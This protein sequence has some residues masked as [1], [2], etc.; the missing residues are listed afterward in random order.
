MQFLICFWGWDILQ[1]PGISDDVTT[2]FKF[3]NLLGCYDAQNVKVVCK[4]DHGGEGGY[5]PMNPSQSV[6]QMSM[7]LKN[8][9]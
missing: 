8:V 1:G 7:C 6:K 5:A 2:I 9:E 3:V 4:P